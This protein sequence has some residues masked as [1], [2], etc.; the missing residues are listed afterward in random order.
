MPSAEE[1]ITLKDAVNQNLGYE[2]R[3]RV[4]TGLVWLIISIRE[5]PH[6]QVQTVKTV[7]CCASINP[8]SIIAVQDSSF[9]SRL[10]VFR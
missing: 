9:S 1:Q 2:V 6:V 3:V 8:P 5:N 10:P 7:V 4:L